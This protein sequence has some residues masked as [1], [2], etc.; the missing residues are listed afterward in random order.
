MSGSGNRSL[1]INVS[2]PFLVR[3]CGYRLRGTEDSEESRAFVAVGY[4][5]SPLSLN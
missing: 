4:D 2:V 1:T 5:N 3:G